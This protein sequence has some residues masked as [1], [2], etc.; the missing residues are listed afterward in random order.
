MWLLAREGM[1]LLLLA[2]AAFRLFGAGAP[3]RGDR[4]ALVEYVVLV[5]ALSVLCLVE[6]PVE[7][8]P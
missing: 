8:T 3:E 7:S 2:V 5:I 6:V 1:L 4:R